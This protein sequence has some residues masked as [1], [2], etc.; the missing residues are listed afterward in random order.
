[1]VRVLPSHLQK[2]GVTVLE[3][4]LPVSRG[5]GGGGK[6]GEK[7]WLGSL[8]WACTTVRF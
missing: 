1:M 8:G 7:G 2:Q 4:R 5:Q 6:D 3:N